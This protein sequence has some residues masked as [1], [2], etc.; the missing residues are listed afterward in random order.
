[1]PEIID[2]QYYEYSR[3]VIESRAIP[4]VVDGLKPVQRRALWVAKKNAQK[5][6]KV[7]KLAGATLSIHP[8]GP[9]SVESA[10]SNMTQYFAGANNICWFDGKGAFGSRIAGPGNGIG[11]ARYVSVKISDNFNNILNT[12]SN[13]IEMIPNY[14]DTEKE[15]KYFLPIIP[16]ILS[17]PIRGIAVGFAC[18]ILPRKISDII[19]CQE[20]YLQGK[21]FREPKVYFEGFKGEI[22]KIEENKWEVTGCFERKTN[23]KI[24]IT[25]LPIGWDRE[26]YIKHLDSLEEKEIISSFTDDCTDSF[27][28]TIKLRK[29]LED[30]EFIDKFKLKNILHE[31]IMV[32][33]VNGKIRKMTVTEIIKEFT[34]FRFKFYLKRFKKMGNENKDDYYLKRDL[35][36]VIQKG[37]FKKFPNLNKKEIRQLLLDNEI[38][39]NN[40]T[41]IINVPIYKFGKEEV[42]KLKNELKE[43]KEKIQYL[44]KLCKNEGLRKNKYIKELKN[45]KNRIK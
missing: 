21:G 30:D 35:L 16:T 18:N 5:W 31:N 37:L 43:L 17:N 11:A 40:I 38:K 42:D 6:I 34:D 4:N 10:I 26:K 3:Y 29:P 25:E 8:H 45:I 36:T 19:R 12:D 14:D 39:E 24:I 28:F 7:S 41:R 9:N 1:I 27:Q 32:I 13:L 22:E 23:K 44:L 20:N 33:D 15:P 2:T